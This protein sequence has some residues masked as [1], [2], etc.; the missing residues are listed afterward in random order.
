MKLRGEARQKTHLATIK[1][2]P[3][4]PFF[5]N[6]PIRPKTGLLGALAHSKLISKLRRIKDQ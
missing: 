2:T 6:L 3:Q 5:S 1:I 4:A